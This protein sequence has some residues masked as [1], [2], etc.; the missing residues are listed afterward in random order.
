MYACVSEVIK[1]NCQ[2]NKTLFISEAFYGTNPENCSS[3]EC[4]APN[5]TLD[6]RAAV[7]ETNEEE[8]LR[9]RSLCNYEN[10]CQY[11]YRG[12]EFAQ[13]GKPVA[14]YVEMTYTCVAGKFCSKLN[15]FFVLYLS[16]LE[17]C[18]FGTLYTTCTL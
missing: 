13:C 8:W 16:N 6:C 10:G 11:Q 12:D 14:D 18:K 7:S 5:D 2:G 3:D 1:I 15:L 17:V 9:M 4:C